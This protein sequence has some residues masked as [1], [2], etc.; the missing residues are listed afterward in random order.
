[1]LFISALQE[2]FK[3]FGSVYKVQTH[4]KIP[5]NDFFFSAAFKN[6]PVNDCHGP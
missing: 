6:A 5:F 2:L 1:M 4:F 3:Y